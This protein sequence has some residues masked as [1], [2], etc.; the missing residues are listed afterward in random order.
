[1]LRS[2]LLM[3]LLVMSSTACVSFENPEL[4]AARAKMAKSSKAFDAA[5][6]T[7][8][9][10][11]A[12]SARGDYQGQ[13]VTF[14]V[15]RK[16]K[17][18]EAR[19]EA[20]DAALAKMSDAKRAKE[21]KDAAKREAAN[22][23]KAKDEEKARYTLKSGKT[24]MPETKVDVHYLEDG[25]Q[26]FKGQWLSGIVKN[27]N[28]EEQAVFVSIEGAPSCFGSI[29]VKESQL[30]AAGSKASK[31]PPSGLASAYSCGGGDYQYDYCGGKSAASCNG[32]QGC[33]W[34][35]GKCVQGH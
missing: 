5:A 12:Y 11:G 26:G 28:E 6:K 23:A 31:Q 20:M 7:G 4:T 32:Q 8:D 13:S 9:V 30:A 27:V 15:L 3:I 18:T 29:L 33:A 34:R 10:D 22:A 24:Y 35:G 2:I 14:D 1:M 16:D 21:E 19:I 17:N 25:L